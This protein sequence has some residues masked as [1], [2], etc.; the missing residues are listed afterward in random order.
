M[1]GIA[2]E[3]VE[4]G[5]VAGAIDRLDRDAF[6]RLPRRAGG[7]VLPVRVLAAVEIQ[8]G[9]GGDARHAATQISS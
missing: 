5:D 1:P 3:E 4:P 6:G 7:G 2:V 9:E 8:L